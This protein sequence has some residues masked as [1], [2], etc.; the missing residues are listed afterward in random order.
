MNIKCS[1][2]DALIFMA[3][4]NPQPAS[5][6]LN[7]TWSINLKRQVTKKTSKLTDI[8]TDGCLKMTNST[9]NITRLENIFLLQTN[10]REL[11]Y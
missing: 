4:L 1:S 5:C 11:S 7:L 3:V 9:A 10:L 8:L 2:N 6:Y